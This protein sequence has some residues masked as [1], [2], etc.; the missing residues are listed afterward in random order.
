MI[1][2]TKRA[3]VVVLTS[4]LVAGMSPASS[5]AQQPVTGSVTGR[6]TDARRPFTDYV[7]QLRNADTGLVVGTTPLDIDGRFAFPTVGLNQKYLIELYH[8]KA[9]HIVCTE[10]PFGLTGQGATSRLEVNIDCGVSPALL[11]IILAGVG[12]ATAVAVASGSR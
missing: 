1:R 6:A 9:N 8:V 11:W 7:I 5:L 10:G 2:V 12:S 3:L 4:L